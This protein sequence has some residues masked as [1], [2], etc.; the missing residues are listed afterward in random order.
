MLSWIFIVFIAHWNNSLRAP[1][2]HFIW[3]PS[4]PIF[5]LFPYCSA[6]KQQ[7]PIL[8]SLVWPDRNSNPR[9]VALKC[10]L[11]LKVSRKAWDTKV[12]IRSHYRRIEGQTLPMVWI[13]KTPPDKNIKTN[14][15]QTNKQTNNCP[16][17]TTHQAKDWATRNPR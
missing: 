8:W 5:A 11:K 15:K 17:N 12:V 2:G 10:K 7:I 4:K 14:K 6:E 13:K 16:Q 3:I 9:S 1:R